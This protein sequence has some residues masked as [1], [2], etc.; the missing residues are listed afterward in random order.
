M[1]HSVFVDRIEGPIA[2]LSTDGGARIELPVALLP[3]GV[4][5]GRWLSLSLTPD[6]G[7]DAASVAEARARRAKLAA[8]DDGGD[9][10]L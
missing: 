8:D 5:E 4:G 3:A 10:S 9:F 1:S 7:K 6:A 2:V